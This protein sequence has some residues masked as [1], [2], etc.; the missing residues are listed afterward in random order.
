MRFNPQGGTSPLMVEVGRGWGNV[1]RTMIDLNLIQPIHQIGNEV[2]GA[3]EPD[4]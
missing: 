3:F 1:N 2:V 4:R